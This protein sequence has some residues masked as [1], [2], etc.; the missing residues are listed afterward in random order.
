MDNQNKSLPSFSFSIPFPFE[1]I[2]SEVEDGPSDSSSPLEGGGEEVWT[3]PRP[4]V[5]VRDELGSFL[6]AGDLL[7][8]EAEGRGEGKVVK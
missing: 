2:A 7:R 8:W 6:V 4:L 5:V 1:S 3:P